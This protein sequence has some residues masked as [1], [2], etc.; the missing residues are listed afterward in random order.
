MVKN[1][2]SWSVED[3]EKLKSLIMTNSVEDCAKLL[4]R[5]LSSVKNKIFRLGLKINIKKIRTDE[6]LWTKDE[7]E[8]LKKLTYE[9]KSVKEIGNILGRS[10]GSID[11]KKMKLGLFIFR[12]TD[13]E[14]KLL[15]E[16]LQKYDRKVISKIL[17]KTQI[18][19]ENKMGE[20]GLRTINKLNPNEDAWLPDEDEFLKNNYEKMTDNFIAECLGRT[21]YAVSH[22]LGRLRFQRKSFEY[23][24]K[25]IFIPQPSEDLAWFLG[26][27]ASDGYID[28][29]GQVGL[30]VV[31]IEFRDKFAF[32]GTKLFGIESNRTIR[33]RNKI[34]SKW[35][36]QYVATFSSR[37]MTDFIGN[38]RKD[39]WVDNLNQNFIWILEDNKYISSF[40][41]SYFDADGCA[42]D[43]FIICSIVDKSKKLI[44]D[45]LNRL[46]VSNHI[47]DEGVY[48]S[49]K[50]GFSNCI[51]LCIPRKDKILE[52]YRNK[53]KRVV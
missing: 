36:D 24:R 41:S 14:E 17:N 42:F 12:W 4:D 27:V 8:L 48:I 46:N 38:M 3:E 2:D 30:S 9:K 18:S 50:S 13:E 39:S 7:E 15:P 51:K 26:T 21:N 45:M 11:F 33:K 28:S 6:K 5:N 22:R 37:A 16:L 40:L 47:I 1:Y 43:G 31:D 23:L 25:E 53:N 34:N 52:Q 19:L 49:D 10:K 44:S 29:N 20:L 32:V 35:L